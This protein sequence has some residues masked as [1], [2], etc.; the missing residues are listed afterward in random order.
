LNRMTH[1]I[2]KPHFLRIRSGT[3]TSSRN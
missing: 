3:L 2:R 1:R